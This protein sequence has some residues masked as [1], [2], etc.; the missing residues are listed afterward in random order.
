MTAKPSVE[1]LGYSRTSLR[2]NDRRPGQGNFRK[3]L[4]LE[5]WLPVPPPITHSAFRTA[6]LVPL[7]LSD[8]P[9]I[10]DIPT[11]PSKG[12]LRTPAAR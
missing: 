12:Y 4:G 1:T 7:A 9:V 8:H 5:Q 2:D 11:V 3:G 6:R 10:I